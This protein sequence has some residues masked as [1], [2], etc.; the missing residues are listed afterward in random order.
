[1]GILLAILV[2]FL[3][4]GQNTTIK[5]AAITSQDSL[6]VTWVLS[7]VSSIV[8]L[9]IFLV[10]NFFYGTVQID[11]N[12]WIALGVK[13]PFMIVALLCYVLAH[14]YGDMSLISPL[15][16]LTPA[17]VLVLAPF[18]VNQQASIGGIVG[19]ILIVVGA[20]FLNFGSRKT[21]YLEPFKMLFKDKGARYMMLTA[22]IWGILTV[23][24]A[25][26]VQN[27]GQNKLQAGIAWAFCT[28]LA[29][30][31]VLAP[32]VAKKAVMAIKSSDRGKLF[33]AGLFSGVME[34]C[35]MIAM[36][37]LLAAYVNAIKRFSM[38]LSVI[39][40]AVFFKEKGIEERL[41]GS[42]I[43]LAGVVMI[44]LLR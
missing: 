19:V 11:Q 17:V 3:H 1:M 36:T 22:I 26:G 25:I 13:L 16:S 14:K 28:Y 2:S 29:M 34:G 39:V 38:V 24:D 27:A 33:L 44:V 8:L 10:L 32:F 12:F 35:Q 41:T 42:L 40:G 37:M 9:P 31:V 21:S 4:T 20:Y 15:L 7:A 43:M 30:A 5:R 18:I 6:V 23:I